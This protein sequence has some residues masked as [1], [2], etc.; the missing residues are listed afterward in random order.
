MRIQWDDASARAQSARAALN[1]IMQRYNDALQEFPA[2]FIVG[3]LG[4]KP[5]GKL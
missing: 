2:R 4:F 3:I 5:A 1:Q